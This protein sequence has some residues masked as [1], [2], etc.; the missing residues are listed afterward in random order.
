MTPESAIFSRNGLLLRRDVYTSA[1]E[2]TAGDNIDIT[3]HVISGRDWTDLIESAV[4]S[5]PQPDLS[6]YYQKN[7]TSSKEELSAAF[8]NCCSGCSA[9]SG[10][11]NIDI[12]EHVVSVTGRKTL[13]IKR[14]LTID[15]DTSSFTIGIDGSGFGDKNIIS[16]AFPLNNDELTTGAPF[17]DPELNGIPIGTPVISKVNEVMFSAVPVDTD[18]NNVGDEVFAY[19]MHVK[20]EQ[21][22]ERDFSL[23]PSAA[24]SGILMYKSGHID[25]VEAPDG[26]V[27]YTLYKNYAVNNGSNT[28]KQNVLFLSQSAYNVRGWVSVMPELGGASIMPLS[29]GQ[30][31]MYTYTGSWDK[32]TNNINNYNLPSNTYTF[33]PFAWTADYPIV[34]I[35][36]K[37]NGAVYTGHAYVETIK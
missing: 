33:I 31:D 32:S 5:I 19:N 16:A 20:N 23:I 2:Y 1:P 27:H 35:G 18:Y 36:I 29:A 13:K 21:G 9:Y 6:N 17:D 11:Q 30:T 28:S 25:V 22:I 4:S 15:Q 12:T 26:D 34:A 24:E 3:N 10:G 37:G 8:D 7:E 14:P